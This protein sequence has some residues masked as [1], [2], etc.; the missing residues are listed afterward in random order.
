MAIQIGE[1]PQRPYRIADAD[2]SPAQA[3]L[4]QRIRSGP[5]KDLPVNM[6]IWLHSPRFAEVVNNFA[7]YVGQLAPMT[8][9]VKEIT[10]LVVAASLGSAFERYWHERLGATLGLSAAQMAAIHA[11]TPARFD[12][13]TEQVAHDLAVALMQ[14]RSVDAALHE[15]AV[16]VM[17]HAGMAELVGLIGL[18]TMVAYSLDIYRVPLPD[19]A[20]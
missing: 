9:R 11:R 19:D 14:Q 18:Y 12:D 4:V 3:D 2:M 16:A 6:E 13:A 20:A 1:H 10:I 7:E 8:R 5:R 15:R 17:G